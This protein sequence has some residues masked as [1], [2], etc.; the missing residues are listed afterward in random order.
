MLAL[1]LAGT[2]HA[3]ELTL[4]ADGLEDTATRQRTSAWAFE[5][6]HPL[7]LKG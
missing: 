4:F 1:A 3:Q 7:R 2:A 5:Y 6:Q